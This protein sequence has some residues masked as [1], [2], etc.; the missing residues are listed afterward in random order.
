LQ[1]K[2]RELHD[3]GVDLM[4]ALS[5]VM[6]GKKLN[7]QFMDL[8]AENLNSLQLEEVLPSIVSSSTSIFNFFK[9]KS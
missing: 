6:R 4:R 3:L 8:M 9:A 7:A 5:G 2:Y 1:G